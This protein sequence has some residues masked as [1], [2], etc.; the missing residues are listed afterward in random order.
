MR[1]IL[2]FDKFKPEYRPIRLF[3]KDSYLVNF[4]ENKT[5]EKEKLV[6][7]IIN[8]FYPDIKKSDT[9][10]IDGRFL[11]SELINKSQK[12]LKILYVISDIIIS[13]NKSVK[14]PD[15]IIN[16]IKDNKFD[17][18]NIDGIYFDDIYN[19]LR[20]VSDSGAMREKE[21][22]NLFKKY[23]L[24]KG[25]DVDILPPDTADD[26]KRGIDAYFK[27]K[28]IPYTIQIKT[29]DYIDLVDNFYHVYISG[30]FTKIKTHYLVL[31][32]N[33]EKKDLFKKS[34]IFK[35]SKIKTYIDEK[36]KSYYLI[37]ISNLIYSE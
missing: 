13:L 36:G 31:I 25:F 34:Y 14:S 27:I 35:G 33:P 5:E 29:L 12:N 24:S 1:L 7:S 17:L 30:D 15:D 16:F 4:D 20:G 19:A 6:R 32:P 3:K 21:G 28:E 2:E 9:I 26:D 11:S 8:E 18:F 10:N 22:S 23:A 37:P